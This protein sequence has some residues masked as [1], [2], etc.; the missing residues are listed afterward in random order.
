[1]QENTGFSSFSDN[2]IAKNVPE[3]GN[4][5]EPWSVR[6]S[7]DTRELEPL[8]E[9]RRGIFPLVH[10]A[11]WPILYSMLASAGHRRNFEGISLEILQSP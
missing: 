2:Y 4:T 9:H 7:A 11:I 1:M 10:P 8:V 6:L 3:S 5:R